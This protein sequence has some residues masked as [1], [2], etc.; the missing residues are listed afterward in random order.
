MLE[1]RRSFIG[2]PLLAACFAG[3]FWGSQA[4]TPSPASPG[5]V[6]RPNGIDDADAIQQRLD[7]AAKQGGTVL[8]TAAPVPYQL[9]HSLRIPTHVSLMGESPGTRLLALQRM[10]K[11]IQVDAPLPLGSRLGTV[12]NLA[13]DGNALADAGLRVEGCVQRAFEHLSIMNCRLSGLQVLGSQNN[14]FLG[15]DVE[16]N[17]TV[18]SSERHGGLELLAG[19]GSNCF[20]RCEFNRNGGYQTLISGKGTAP[21]AFEAGPSGN[22]FMSCIFERRQANTRAAIYAGGGRLNT[23]LRCDVSHD[24][25]VM[26]EGPD[27][28]SA[29]CAL[30]RFY[31][32]GF[33]GSPSTTFL[34]GGN[35]TW[36]LV[37]D[38]C[39][40]ES[41][42]SIS[43]AR[44]SQRVTIL[45][46]NQ[47]SGVAKWDSEALLLTSQTQIPGGR[48]DTPHIMLGSAH[49]WV[50]P[51]GELRYS[52]HAPTG[53]YDGRKLVSEGS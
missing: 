21:W 25:P 27:D 49:L 32:C 11:I 35:R 5:F 16:Y 50:D 1:S 33:S 47:V 34:T 43:D 40:F 36:G 24:G 3:P 29:T 23:W 31:A 44:S 2:S 15:V 37:F 10:D 30:W 12:A 7:A 41:F 20:V 14:L 48:W 42:E 9:S 52:T 18:V 28:P 51:Q 26:I 4:S 6:Y 46:S 22:L 8:L 13:L 45:P 17:G 39:L 38:A 19:A 53:P